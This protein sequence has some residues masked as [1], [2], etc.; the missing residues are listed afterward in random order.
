M[1]PLTP[2]NSGAPEYPLQLGTNQSAAGIAPYSQAGLQ[3]AS[4]GFPTKAAPPAVLSTGPSPVVLLKGVRRHLGLAL[5]LG[6]F[7][8]GVAA[9]VTWYALPTSK[10]T[11]RSMLQVSATPPTVVFRDAADINTHADARGEFATYKQTQEVMIKSRFVLNAALRYPSIA[12]LP[13]IRKQVDPV[14]WLANKLTIL[15]TGEIMQISLSGNDPQELAKLV[16]AVTDAYLLEVVQA[17]SRQRAQHHG[18]LQEIHRDYLETL[19]A[20]RNNLK[21]LAEVAG[22]S[23]QAT[24]QV[25]H[26]L[27]M[28]RHA[29]AAREHD[30]LRNERLQAEMDLEFQQNR[31]K[32]AKPTL[33]K[34]ELENLIN[35]DSLI[36]Q[37][38]ADVRKAMSVVGE[39]DRRARKKNDPALMKMQARLQAA[40]QTLAEEKDKLRTDLLKQ[41]MAAANVNPNEELAQLLEKIKVLKKYEDTSKTDRDKLAKEL[42]DFGKTTISLEEIKDQISNTEAAA[43]EIG[44]Q[45]EVLGV[46]LKARDR[47]RLVERAEVPRVINI[48]KHIAATGFAG[49]SSLALVLIGIAFWETRVQ[50]V[51]TVDEVVHGLGMGLVGVLPALPSPSRRLPGKTGKGVQEQLWNNILLESVDATRAMILHASR[52]ESLRVLMVASALKGEGKTSL[53]CHLATSLARARKRTLLIDC[54]LRNPATHRMFDVLSEPGVCEI[55]RGEITIADA[56]QP[57]IASGLSIITA[58]KCDALAIQGLAQG[59]LQSLIDEVREQYEYVVVDSAP[60]LPVADSLQVCQHVDAVVFSIL[61]DVSR[62]PKVYAA[63]E[64]LAMLGVRMLGVVVAGTRC[65]NYASSYAYNLPHSE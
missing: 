14:D 58:G 37:L 5:T 64:R 40:Q 23:D 11:A 41:Q 2:D 57:T 10:Y 32:L 19:T 46:E 49:L 15:Y 22:S 63:Y 13:S 48:T 55:L 26:A 29:T 47:V 7:C 39:Y 30:R 54:D 52:S 43:K 36:Q 61:R 53:A 20:K 27:E 16:N 31:P 6:L 42:Q 28:E 59:H 65:E 44:H 45:V 50:R 4:G 25:K 38:A 60:V 12:G 56:V 51:D 8:A 1:A 35:N 34:K 62:L 33:S 9:I 17:D 21:K 24:L 18:H 3:P